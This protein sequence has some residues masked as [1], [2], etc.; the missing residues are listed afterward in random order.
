MIKRFLPLIAI[1]FILS[2]ASLYA[3]PA[4]IYG[5]VADEQSG[6]VLV[7]ANIFLEGTHLGTSTDLDGQY[8]ITGIPAGNYTLIASIVSYARKKV[9]DLTLGDS[10]VL[11]LDLVLTPETIEAAEV[12]VEAELLRG[13][14]SG[15]LKSRQRAAGV[16]DAISAE[17]I[18]R[19]TSSNVADAMRSVTGVTVVDGR[20]IHVRGLGDRYNTT[21]LNGVVLPS[22]NPD[23]NSVSLDLLPAKFVDNIV[24]EK[25]FTADKPG[26]YTGGGVHIQTKSFPEK[27]SLSMSA[28]SSINSETALKN[29]FLTHPGGR[30]DWLG[31]DDGAR[32]IPPALQNPG[33]LPEFSATFRDREKALR[34]DELSNS[35]NY[36]MYPLTK[37]AP[38]DHSYTFS[39]GDQTELLGM[40]VG[41]FGSL[42]YAR[43][44]SS[45]VNG[46]SAQYQLTGNIS[47]VTE[48]TNLYLLNDSRST[49]HVLWGG[50]AS[51]SIKP[52]PL[53]SITASFNYSRA[54]ES[55][56]RYLFGPV[57]RDFPENVTFETRV[58]RYTE[59]ELRA[60]R[61]SGDHLLPGFLNSKIEWKIATTSSLQDEPDLRYFSDDYT[62]VERGGGV[63]TL[64]SIRPSNYA[65]PSRYFRSLEDGNN[66]YGVAATIPFRDVGGLNGS[67]KLGTS[68]DRKD[69]TFSERRFEYKATSLARY[70][71][72][73]AE[74]FSPEMV[75]LVDTTDGFYRFGLYLVEASAMANNYMGMQDV[76]A[77]FGMVDLDL[78]GGFRLIVGLRAEFTDL[79]V[80]S[81]DAK[82]EMSTVITD[83][84][85]PS[86]SVIYSP[87]DRMNVRLVYGKTLARPT[88]REL[89]PFASFDF[90]GDFIFI[91]NPTLRRTLVDNY[92]IRWEWFPGPSELLA[93]SVF[94]KKF[95]DPIERAIVSN[96]NQGQF[97]NV[98]S[99]LVTGG[100]LE[101]RTRLDALFSSLAE[102]S[103]QTN[104]TI[105]YSEV[106]VP[107]KELIVVQSLNP[108]A[109]RTRE[110]QGQSP[111]MFNI[112]L[113]YDNRSLGTAA[114]VSYN[115]FGKRLS[116][117]SLGGTPNVYELPRSLVDIV[118]TQ[119]ILGNFEAKFAVKN[120]LDSPLKMAQ[121]YKGKEF[122]VAEH[123]L[124]RV[125][126]V[127][128][129]YA[130]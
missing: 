27:F 39:A 36:N 107:E 89:A 115:V 81:S 112:G 70:N 28:S 105:V 80:A 50:L 117:V 104:L 22:A 2:I 20:F 92:D 83:D 38:I 111:Y 19:T 99:A 7:G 33:V 11:K 48:L 77:Y 109:A 6:E 58:L 13:I 64:Y 49:E 43:D 65:V 98:P 62:V 16:S 10:E 84:Y 18:S 128:L 60:F 85:L 41:Y 59:R 56:S 52:S 114:T 24:T 9:T 76:E 51:L 95:R 75:G 97:Q 121:F 14:E 126:S 129:S 3:Q 119:A 125:F 61:F 46:I 74:Y 53:H 130:M 87:T 110:L 30:T 90:V 55:E 68:L 34:L 108:G 71:G 15:L 79:S 100:E 21:M 12:V 116:K 35:F 86:A 91:G 17:A 23:R 57:P 8:R 31:I 96:N 93:A 94:Y 5:T 42:S 82:Q 120:L 78:N 47:E 69:R 127:R 101:L 122:V 29:S 63:D 54:G 88:F 4:T 40:P 44:F 1:L 37:K 67:I 26:D 113:G 25:T 66:T 124:G 45:Y 73:P 32:A 102:F 72:D 103:L 123:N 118:V 106:D